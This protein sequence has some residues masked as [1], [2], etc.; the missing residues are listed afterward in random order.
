MRTVPPDGGLTRAG[1]SKPQTSTPQDPPD[2]GL[3]GTGSSGPE[4][5]TPADDPWGETALPAPEL[6]ELAQSPTAP[7]VKPS[8]WHADESTRAEAAR[9]A[10]WGDRATNDSDTGPPSFAT[11]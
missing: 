10:V 5:S 11:I 7:A 6:P 3:E 9:F 4:P 1:N 8:R 2:G